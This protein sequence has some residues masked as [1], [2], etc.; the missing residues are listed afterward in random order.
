MEIKTSETKKNI[1]ENCH[2]TLYSLL[3]VSVAPTVDAVSTLLSDF[4]RPKNIDIWHCAL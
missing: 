3:H 2:Y 4:Y 1:D